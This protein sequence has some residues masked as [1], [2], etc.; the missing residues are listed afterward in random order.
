MPSG[1]A[2]LRAR[3]EVQDI[4]W[5]LLRTRADKLNQAF[6]E[7]QSSHFEALELSQK[8]HILHQE[9]PPGVVV[10]NIP[11]SVQ[12]RLDSALD[13][14][15]AQWLVDQKSQFQKYN[16]AWWALQPALLKAGWL[17][18]IRNLKWKLACWRYAILPVK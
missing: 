13:L 3:L 5:T 11:L 17:A 8:T 10:D 15:Y 18:Q 14:F 16:R 4:H 6:W 1:L 2:A 9:S 7:H 12:E